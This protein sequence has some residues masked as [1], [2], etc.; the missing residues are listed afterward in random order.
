MLN[1]LNE[2]LR[3]KL[4]F[5]SAFA[6]LIGGTGA[7]SAQGFDNPPGSQ[8]QNKGIREDNGLPPLRSEVPSANAYGAY[9]AYGYYTGRSSVGPRRMHVVRSNRGRITRAD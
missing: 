4:L 9:G 1:R 5:A 8:W 2:N 6:A 7:A 3:S